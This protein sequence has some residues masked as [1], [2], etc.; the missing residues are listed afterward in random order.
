MSSPVTENGITRYARAD[1]VRAADAIRQR[2]ALA[3]RAGMVLGSGLG[4]LADQVADAV[5]IP[6]ADIPGFP[7]STVHGHRGELVI[8]TLEGCPVVCQRGRAHFY[9]GYTPQQITFPIRVMAMLG[10]DTLILTNAAGGVN[11]AYRVADVMV[12][13]DHLNFVGA[14][15]HNP[16]MGPNDDSIGP[17]FPGM[18][19]PYD[20]RLVAQAMAVGQAAGI[21]VHEGVYACVSGPNFE[22]PAEIRMLRVMGADAVGMSTVHETLIARHMGVRV[23]ALSGITNECVDDIHASSE[24][25]HEE[26]LEAGRVIVPRMTAI[27]R[28][29]LRQMAGVAR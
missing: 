19:Q 11:R 18:T 7:V 1:F 13:N 29:V 9:E 10:I 21:P 27:L 4:G 28:G 17:R 5:V 24:A 12:M 2:T 3:V 8:G 15:G 16:L 26:V 25:N 14:A 23:L 6:Y 22:T 20:A